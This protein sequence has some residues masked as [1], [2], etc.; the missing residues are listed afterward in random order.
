MVVGLLYKD[1]IPY[2]GVV[3]DTS[4]PVLSPSV[5]ALLRFGLYEKA[6]AGFIAKYL[7]PDQD[8]VELGS[9]LGVTAACIARK[10][11]PEHQLVCVEANEGLLQQIEKN[12][13]NNSPSARLS[14]IH[15]AISY[16]GNAL[17]PFQ[18]G[19]LNTG[20]RVGGRTFQGE[21]VPSLRLSEVLA[22][23]GV[24]EF[25]LVCDI[26][27]SEKEMLE[28]ESLEGCSQVIIELHSESVSGD[29]LDPEDMLALLDRKGFRTV[30]RH[31]GVAYCERRLD[32]KRTLR[33]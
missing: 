27:G 32:R 6:E 5:K 20:G 29:Y 16:E 30:D 21:G 31:G 23:T 14:V 3:I 25:S 4:H 24:G 28:Q 12:V 22:S 15:G 10:M 26:E 33:K 2:R 7:R 13:L 19:A 17:T 18:P 11:S 8:V 1:R 9:S